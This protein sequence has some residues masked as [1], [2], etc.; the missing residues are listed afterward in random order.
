MNS[1]L[2]THR[3]RKFMN[4]LDDEIAELGNAARNHHMN[5][6]K[7]TPEQQFLLEVFGA[8]PKGNQKWRRGFFCSYNAELLLYLT[9][10]LSLLSEIQ[11]EVL[12]Q[13]S[14]HTTVI[15]EKCQFML[16]LVK[17]YPDTVDAQGVGVSA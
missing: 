7:E 2:M 13:R 11:M 16:L 9:Y 4:C 15:Y 1:C 14:E 12:M 10:G 17:L 3:F 6:G 5:K 8:L